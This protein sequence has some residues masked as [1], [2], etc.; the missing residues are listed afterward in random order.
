MAVYDYICDRDYAKCWEYRLTS[1]NTGAVSIGFLLRTFG[2]PP[3]KP[4]KC[5]NGIM[6]VVCVCVRETFHVSDH[7][8]VKVKCSKS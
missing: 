3:A 6:M 7:Q 8:I 2:P 1:R 4:D 5:E